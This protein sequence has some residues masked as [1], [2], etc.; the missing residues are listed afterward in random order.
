[1]ISE[2]LAKKRREGE[3]LKSVEHTD[4]KQIECKV[5]GGR[6]RLVACVRLSTLDIINCT[7]QHWE[8][9]RKPGVEVE[10]VEEHPSYTCS[11]TQG[12]DNLYVDNR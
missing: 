9:V 4:W 8:E 11:C 1:M 3:K 2:M 5:G 10:Y 7:Y 12:T 6:E